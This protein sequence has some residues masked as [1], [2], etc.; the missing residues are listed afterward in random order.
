MTL[1]LLTAIGG[2]GDWK[3]FIVG[4]RNGKIKERKMIGSETAPVTSPKVREREFS[5]RHR[6]Q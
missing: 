3:D 1:L 4:L 2:D 5:L 6:A